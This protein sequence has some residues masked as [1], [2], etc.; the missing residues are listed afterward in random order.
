MKNTLIT[1]LIS[2]FSIMGY[3]QV[4]ILSDSIV[5]SEHSTI[6]P[7]L[8][9][10][11]GFQYDTLFEVSFTWFS[12]T[13]N[14]RVN[15]GY[16]V[17]SYKM[18]SREYSIKGKEVLVHDEFYV[19]GKDGIRYYING[20]MINDIVMDS[21]RIPKCGWFKKLFGCSPRVIWEMRIVSEWEMPIS[22]ENK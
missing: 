16:L 18:F 19:I 3:S 15:N 17:Q 11:A 8:L 20:V 21:K 9:Y 22:P 2:F 12:N 10:E 6:K 13:G 5:F 7:M 14:L 4:I 1:L